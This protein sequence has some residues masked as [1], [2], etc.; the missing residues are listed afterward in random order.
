MR[1][2]LS[3]VLLS[4][5][6]SSGCYTTKLYYADVEGRDGKT[7]VNVQHTFFWGLL[8]P[9]HVNLAGYCDKNGIKEIK[10]QVTGWGLLANW[11][12]GGIWIPMRV[13]VTCA[14]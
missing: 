1:R 7:H 9:G 14:K 11:F 8:S 5:L 4:A 10:S 12:T 6:L 2:A 3:L 13:K